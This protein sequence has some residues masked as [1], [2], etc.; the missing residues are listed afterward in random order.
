MSGVHRS[1]LRLYL[2]ISLQIPLHL[3]L[4]HSRVNARRL[5]VEFLTHD[6]RMLS[7]SRQRWR[8][9]EKPGICSGQ[10]FS[11]KRLYSSRVYLFL[12]QSRCLCS[13]TKDVKLLSSMM[14]KHGT[15]ESEDTSRHVQHANLLS[16]AGRGPVLSSASSVSVRAAVQRSLK[17]SKMK[18]RGKVS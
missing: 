12:Q 8:R 3:L 10:T 14:Y 9:P 5:H 7:M 15:T 6:C 13:I 18:K 16:W 4:R 11:S 17:I 2:D 1:L